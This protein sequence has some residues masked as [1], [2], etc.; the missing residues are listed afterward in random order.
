MA[1]PENNTNAEKWTLQEAENF[2]NS[3][4]ALSEDRN[5][6]FIGEIAKEMKSYKEI[7]TYLS[8][9]Y[10]ELKTLHNVLLS[11]CEANCFYNGKKQN[12]VPSLAI[13]NLKSNHGWTD[14][15]DNTTKGNEISTRPQIIFTDE[16]KGKSEVSEDMDN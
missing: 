2:F 8:D 3:A 14:R 16:S 6:D 11:N 4:I 12:I 7:F 5:Y 10:K 9:K 13:M 15:I 1:A